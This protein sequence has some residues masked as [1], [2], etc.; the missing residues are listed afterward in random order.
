MKSFLTKVEKYEGPLL[1]FRMA[2]QQSIF[3]LRDG[4]IIIARDWKDGYFRSVCDG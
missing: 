1:I 2:I 4:T 3:M